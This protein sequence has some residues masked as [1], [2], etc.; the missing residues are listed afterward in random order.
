MRKNDAKCSGVIFLKL[1]TRFV[2]DRMFGK[3]DI[4]RFIATEPDL[5]LVLISISGYFYDKSMINNTK[6]SLLH[7]CQWS[8]EIHCDIIK[9]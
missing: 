6:P 3:W 9:K 4:W 7:F 5:L 1:Q 8:F 2:R